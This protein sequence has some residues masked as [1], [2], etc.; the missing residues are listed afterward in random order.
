M[1]IDD[2]D[3][4]GIAIVPCKADA[5]LLV[6]PDCILS[7]PV[8]SE[9]VKPVPWIQHQRL[10]A[11]SSMQDHQPLSRLPLKRLKSSNASV[12]KKLLSVPAGKRF[13]HIRI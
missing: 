2:F 1:V 11:G 6:D 4:V 10:Q 7:L 5:P 8:S 9:S 3:I 12:V 13:D